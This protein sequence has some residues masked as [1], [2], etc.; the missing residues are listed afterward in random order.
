MVTP[1]PGADQRVEARPERSGLSLDMPF[2]SRRGMT[3][4]LTGLMAVKIALLF[5]LAWNTRFV[6]DEFVQFGLAKYLGNGLFDTV[7]PGKS[8][9]YAVFYKLAHLIGWD[10]RSMLLLGRMQTALLALATIAAVYGCA[11]ALGST[12]LESIAVILVLL[13]FS[14]F[15]ERIFR[16]IAEPLAV[17]FAVAALLIVLRRGTDRWSVMLAG[18]LSGLAFLTTQKSVYFNVALGLALVGDAALRR[19]YLAG[20]ARGAWL[21]IGWLISV[22]AYCFVFGGSDPIPIVKHLILGPAPVL[23]AQ[24]PAEYGGLRHFVMQTLVR[25]ALLYAFCFGGMALALLRIKALNGAARIALMFTLVITLLVFTHDQPW[26]YVFI[27]ALP[28]IT[29]WAMEPLRAIRTKPLYAPA[30]VAI[31]GVGIAASFARNVAYLKHDNHQQLE[32]AKRAESLLGPDDVY[33]DG[34]GMLPNRREPTMLWLD[35]HSILRT[36]REATNSEAYRIFANTPPRLIIWSYRMDGIE[37][38]VGDLIRDSYVRV[39]PNVRMAGRRLR[40]GQPTKFNV[41][42]A[43][44]YALYSADGRPLSGELVAGSAIANG[45]VH[46]NPG[47]VTVTLR[48]GA[49]EALLLPQG[50]YAGRFELG[51][52]RRGLFEGVYD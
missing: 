24:V 23:S 35:R 6:M 34:N 7:W 5:V 20:V 37:P 11:R 1:L 30:L 15:M 44:T 38:V 43:G 29:L 36:I 3:I 45:A 18:A 14:N 39:A 9:G 47:R 28:F 21:V 48:S 27:M 22:A 8:V 32:I 31:L 26:P 42:L 2:L 12:K 10:A 4:A 13:S 16:T 51:A 50:S 40:A 49:A 19:M 33:F 25:N 17:F 41:P 52:D 46:L